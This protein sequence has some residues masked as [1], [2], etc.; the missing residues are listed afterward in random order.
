M[1]EISFDD[2]IVCTFIQAHVRF[3]FI[4]RKERV[5]FRLPLDFGGEGRYLKL[6]NLLQV[7]L[8]VCVFK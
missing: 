8:H 2:D 3:M 7:C 6:C 1:L 4:G 5:V